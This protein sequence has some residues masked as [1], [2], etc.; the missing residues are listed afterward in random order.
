MESSQSRF[1]LFVVTGT[2]AALIAGGIY[3]YYLRKDRVVKVANNTPQKNEPTEP[4]F[5]QVVT[6]EPVNT[7]ASNTSNNNVFVGHRTSLLP[8][9]K[10]VTST[11]KSLGSRR[12]TDEQIEEYYTGGR[13]S[14]KDVFEGKVSPK[15]NS[16]DPSKRG[17][18]I[19]NWGSATHRNFLANAKPQKK[20]YQK[21]LKLDELEKDA[22]DDRIFR[23]TLDH[24]GQ[25]LLSKSKS[26]RKIFRRL[27]NKYYGYLTVEAFRKILDE[28]ELGLQ[29][30]TTEEKDT[31]VNYCN[32]AD[33]KIDYKEFFTTF[34]EQTIKKQL[35][36]QG[37]GTLKQ[38]E[39]HS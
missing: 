15:E 10:P 8:T 20:I 29:E 23:K 31:I 21:S 33:G 26:I 18:Q 24:I 16:R 3:L 5:K 7:S 2:T 34:F 32:C 4:K 12:R 37:K 6:A 1:L 14:R 22:S 11:G 27:D 39:I 17:I 19:K 30:L 36:T 28:P 38:I 35:R 13:A 9:D 25:V